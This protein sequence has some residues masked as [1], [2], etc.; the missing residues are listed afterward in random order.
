MLK[1]FSA[2]AVTAMGAWYLWRSLRSRDLDV[3]W[4]AHDHSKVALAVGVLPCPLTMLI[5]SAAFSYASLGVGLL[6]VAV[7]G[8]GIL[9]TIGAVGS[10]GIAL[11]RLIAVSLTPATD[12]YMLALRFL[13][14]GS[15]T[16]ILALGISALGTIW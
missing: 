11:Q 7:M 9:A 1:S 4:S 15:A 14:I 10:I 5:L 13:E 2:V 6:L 3:R 8:L 12:R 16:I